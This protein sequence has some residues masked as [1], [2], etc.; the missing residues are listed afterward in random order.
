MNQL[1]VSRRVLLQ[2]TRRISK[3]V[4]S[5]FAADMDIAVSYAQGCAGKHLL[6]AAVDGSK[7]TNG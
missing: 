5:L 3:R 2:R 4:V 7:I 6:L 1:M